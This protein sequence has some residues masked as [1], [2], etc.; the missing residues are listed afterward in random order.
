M[1][2]TD[3][4]V[5]PLALPLK[6]PYVWSQGV[7]TRFHVNLV[8]LIGEDGAIGV[9]ETTTAPD[10]AAQA[11][12]LRKL[13]R[14][15]IGR[16][17]FEAR[18]I[19]AEAYRANFLA[20]G[21][22][23]PRYA[24][25]LMS[26][27]DMAALDLQGQ[28][29][30]RPVWDLLGGAVRANVGYFYFL[31]GETV[32]EL[33]ADARA[34]VAAGN[35][36]IYLKV[37]IEPERDIAATRAVRAAIGDTR[38]RLDANE[39]WDPGLALRMLTR[40]AEFDIE[41]I[42]QPTPSTAI[43]ALGQVARQSP[44]AIGADQSVFTL[45]EVYRAVSGG[46]AHM[47]AIGPREIGG[48]QPMIKAA[49]IAEAAGLKICIHSSMTTGISTVAE[50]HAARAIPNLDDGNQI[51]WQLLEEDVLDRP[52]V[53]PVKGRLALEGKPGL[54]TVLDRDVI[55]RAAERFEAEQA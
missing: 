16:P 38:L 32:E 55:G 49:A 9:G 12:V 26:G 5:T 54:G 7:E 27:L 15:F 24:N 4:R 41:Y 50:H 34:A 13:G 20:F 17:V 47:I 6:R 39:A 25:Q 48:V 1:L 44:I 46:H 23:M 3:I 2:V 10:A 30:G 31:Q 8:E 11:M 40:L 14:H 33:A 22:N 43:E 29:T 28:A 53:A 45:N 37:G 42:E 51:M 19:M 35:P 52:G 36:V 18:Q 21:G